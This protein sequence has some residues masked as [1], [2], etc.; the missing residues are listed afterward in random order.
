M[1]N[2]HLIHPFFALYLAPF[3]YILRLLLQ[4]PLKSV[5]SSL[6]P[7]HFTLFLF[8][9]HIFPPND[10]SLFDPLGKGELGVLQ[11]IHTATKLIHLTSTYYY[12]VVKGNSDNT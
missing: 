1:Q 9:F 6:F 11:Y 12:T 10:I 5:V 3:A 7:S 2:L 8:P 4:L